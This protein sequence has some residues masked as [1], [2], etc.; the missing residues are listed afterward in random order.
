[1]SRSSV[2]SIIPGNNAASPPNKPL[3]YPLVLAAF[4]RAEEVRK[5][6]FWEDLRG[7]LVEWRGL[8]RGQGKEQGS[9]GGVGGVT[10]ARERAGER[11]R[12]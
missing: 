1:M 9:E 8:G 6:P 4:R 5:L 11:A 10:R 2:T 12:E 3:P 7:A